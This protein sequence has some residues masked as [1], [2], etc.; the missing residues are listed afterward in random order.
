MICKFKSKSGRECGGAGTVY[1]D[2]FLRDCPRCKGT[3][4][5]PNSSEPT[6]SERKDD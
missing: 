3:G 5:E 4:E 6:Y 1:I 2:G